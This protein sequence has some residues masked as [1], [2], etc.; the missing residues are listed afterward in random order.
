MVGEVAAFSLGDSCLQPGECRS[1]RQNR[2]DKK[3]RQA[4][5]AGTAA[6]VTLF[7]RW[8]QVV[9]LAGW[10]GMGLGLSDEDKYADM[11]LRLGKN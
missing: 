5:L 11:D 7:M 3:A 9:D 6:W 8:Q 4:E 10:G 2:S 1:R